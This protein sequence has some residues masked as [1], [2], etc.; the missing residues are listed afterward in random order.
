MHS[1]SVAVRILVVEDNPFDEELLRR[2]LRRTEMAS[3]TTFV[4]DPFQAMELLT[5]NESDSFRQDLIAIF[6]DIHLPGMSG[7]ELLR[8][9]RDMPGMEDF[10]VIMMTSC[11]DPR[12]ME[13]CQRLGAKS[14][15]EKP[16]TVASFSKAIANLF[17]DHS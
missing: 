4:S 7:I 13:E 15:V 2:Q 6:L 12:D 10:P 11:P 8:H 14:Y 1:A 3:K 9:I 5:G 16:V 17:H